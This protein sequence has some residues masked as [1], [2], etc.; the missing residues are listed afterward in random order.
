MNYKIYE[1]N[2]D[3][4]FKYLPVKKS[5]RKNKNISNFADSPFSKL[6]QLN[7]K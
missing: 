3:V 2:K 4:L 1:K 6:T 5:S 7:I